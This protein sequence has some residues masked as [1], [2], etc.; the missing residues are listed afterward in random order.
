MTTLGIV[1]TVNFRY[2]GHPRDRDLVSVIAK[3]RISGVRE[4]FY[5]IENQSLLKAV[6]KDPPLLQKREVFGKRTCWSKAL[7]VKV[8]L[9]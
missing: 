2:S 9:S 3:V 6:Y 8:F 5:L 4:N 1:F 7:K